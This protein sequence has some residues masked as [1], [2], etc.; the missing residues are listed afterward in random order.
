MV[1]GFFDFF[2][3]FVCYLTCGF[4]VLEKRT[5]KMGSKGCEIGQCCEDKKVCAFV[6][7][8]FNLSYLMSLLCNCLCI[9]VFVIPA[10]RS[11]LV[12]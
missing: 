11:L 10:N 12:L 9:Y 5:T 6:Y 8:L 1:V 7:L 3:T 2:C 4:T